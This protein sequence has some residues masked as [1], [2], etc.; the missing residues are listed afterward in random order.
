MAKAKTPGT[1]RVQQAVELAEQRFSPATAPVSRTN[2]LVFI[3]HDSRDADLAEA[4]DHFLTD[5]SGG[6]IRTF[7][8][9]D[10]TGRAGID[11]G[12]DWFSKVTNVLT[13]ASDVVAL[14]TPNSVG[15]P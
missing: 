3:S 1:R 14:L 5:A 10:Q 6:V 7:R 8:S 12:E 13:D 2:P 4:F 9:S 11:Y 15:R